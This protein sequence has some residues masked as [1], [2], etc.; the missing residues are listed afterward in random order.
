M[1]GQD[2]RSDDDGIV[3]ESLSAA[4]AAFDQTVAKPERLRQAP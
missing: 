1:S 2:S 3:V 4:A